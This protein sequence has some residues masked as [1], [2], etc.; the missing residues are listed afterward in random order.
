M[1]AK[2]RRPTHPTQ[3][4]AQFA[5]ASELCKRDYQVALTMG[6]HPKADLMAIS[7]NGVP[8]TVDVKGLRSKNTWFVRRK[9]KTQNLFYVLACVPPG[10]PN[11]FFL[12]N[13]A[14]ADRLIRGD[15]SAS[16]I[17]WRDCLPH[18]DRWDALPD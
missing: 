2:K 17:P 12:M 9:P 1:T 13:Q 16:D 18:L 11:Q 10:K 6:N 3:W 4:A 15:T 7:P 5:V 14:T 8:F